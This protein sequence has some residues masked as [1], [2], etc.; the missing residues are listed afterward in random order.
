MRSMTVKSRD[1]KLS[2]SKLSYKDVVFERASR[3]SQ[4][5]VCLDCIIKIAVACIRDHTLF[6]LLQ[7]WT[8]PNVPRSQDSAVD[9]LPKLKR[10][11]IF[12]GITLSRAELA[13]QEMSN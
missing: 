6:R 3:I 11:A 1:A 9:P 2:W 12:P 10:F 5:V 8:G 13:L 4:I 7:L